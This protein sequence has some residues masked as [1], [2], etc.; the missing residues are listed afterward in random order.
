MISLDFLDKN[1]VDSRSKLEIIEE[2]ILIDILSGGYRPGQR[3]I[4]QKICDKYDISRTPVREILNRLVKTGLVEIIP[5]RGA[6][7]IGLSAEE[8]DNIFQLKIL[9][10]PQAVYWAIENI[11]NSELEMLE[12]VYGFISFYQPTGDIERIIKF[13]RGFDQIIYDAT[14]NRELNNLL[15]KYDFYIQH[16]LSNPYFPDNYL[17]TLVNEYQRIFDA[18]RLRDPNLG[19][20]AAQIHITRSYL[21]TKA[22][23]F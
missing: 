13:C 22:R 6:F 5:N 19:M 12:E 18:F 20:E 14:K 3:I 15:I 2:K 17:S 11:T 1:Y 7:V 21:R 10:Y 16:Y 8:M 4:E 9:L 23:Q